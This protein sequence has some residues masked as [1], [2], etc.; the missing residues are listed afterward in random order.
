MRKK[1]CRRGHGWKPSHPLFTAWVD[2]A[3]RR[4]DLAHTTEGTQAA[5]EATQLLH[6]YM[7]MV[8]AGTLTVS[9]LRETLHKD[10][11]IRKIADCFAAHSLVPVEIP[12]WSV[13]TLT[14]HWLVEQGVTLELDPKNLGG[15][16]SI[17]PTLW[18]LIF[19]PSG[20]GK[21]TAARYLG[22]NGLG[23]TPMEPPDSTAAFR[24]G[25][26]E[27]KGEP[28][29]MLWDEI[30]NDIAQAS[31][32]NSHIA[33]VRRALLNAYD[34][35]VRKNL[36][37]SDEQR[38]PVKLSVLGLSVLELIHDQFGPD[39][40]KSGLMQRFTLV[41]GTAPHRPKDSKE[42][43]RRLSIGTVL[44]ELQ[45]EGLVTRWK[46]EV[47]SQTLHPRYLMSEAGLKYCHMRIGQL[48]TTLGTENSFALRALFT[49]FKLSLVLH[50]LHKRG[51]TEQID[52][53]DCGYAFDII[54]VCLH[55]LQFLADTGETSELLRLYQVS[56]AAYQRLED[57]TLVHTPEAMLRWLMR[58][59][60][61]KKNVDT[62]TIKFI[63]DRLM[64]A[65]K[66]GELYSESLLI[67]TP[68]GTER[69][70]LEH[71]D[72]MED[73]AKAVGGL[74]GTKLSDEALISAVT[75][76]RDAGVSLV[77]VVAESAC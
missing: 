17:S 39:D 51:A 27:A 30:G 6:D 65:I 67:T 4:D 66:G 72:A 5:E 38:E 58:Y 32:K 2:A 71:T 16:N 19:A 18:T 42:M 37:S 20:S 24:D 8:R 34:G 43:G 29:Q 62:W 1:Q 14:G 69:V 53:E 68:E 33:G 52:V 21:T 63:R 23:G 57:T 55:D 36:A 15:F 48:M 41:A 56:V 44:T 49:A 3:K 9:P 22:S 50:I 76:L 74:D 7:A 70:I 77:P 54:E 26:L 35:Y 75:S 12:I 13:L 46:E 10:S 64:A 11:T 60:L 25:L 28:R 45:A 40:W 59:P 61:S 47:T 73:K 31:S